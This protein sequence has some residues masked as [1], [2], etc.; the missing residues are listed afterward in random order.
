MSGTF[1]FFWKFQPNSCRSQVFFTLTDWGI[2]SVLSDLVIL[3]PLPLRTLSSKASLTPCTFC[4]LISIST[5]RCWGVVKGRAVWEC[6]CLC[7]TKCIQTNWFKTNIPLNKPGRSL[8]FL[9]CETTWCVGVVGCLSSSGKVK[10]A[11]G[12]WRVSHIFRLTLSPVRKTHC[13]LKLLQF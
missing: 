13:R 3:S 12:R 2:V 11:E 4:M 8:R 10:F 9:K 5:C 7:Q 6:M 1:V